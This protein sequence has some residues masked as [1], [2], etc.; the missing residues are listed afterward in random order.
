MK[1]RRR[2]SSETKGGENMTQ[3]NRFRFRV[4]DQHANVMEPIEDLY[5]FEENGVHESE[6]LDGETKGANTNFVLMQST[7]LCDK[8]G[9]EIFEGDVVEFTNWWFDGN[10]AETQLKGTIVYTPELMSFQLKGVQNKEWQ[11]H[12]GHSGDKYMTAFSELTFDE[13]DFAVLGNIYEN[14]ELLEK[15]ENNG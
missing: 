1:V 9:V 5:W 11:A 8:N 10:V 6:G 15:T 2:K 14:P 13:A 3:A 12:T 4:W 7:G